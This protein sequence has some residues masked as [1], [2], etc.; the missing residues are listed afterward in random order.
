[1]ESCKICEW[2]KNKTR[3][4]YETSNNIIIQPDI[5]YNPYC[6]LVCPKKHYDNIHNMP[7]SEKKVLINETYHFGKKLE[8]KFGIKSVR[9]I[10]NNNFWKVSKSK[11]SLGHVHFNILAV[12]KKPYS[13]DPESRKIF[14][15]EELKVPREEIRGLFHQVRKR[16]IIIIEGI[17]GSGK[18]TIIEHLKSKITDAFEIKIHGFYFKNSKRCRNVDNLLR[19]TKNKII[20]VCDLVLCLEYDDVIISRFHISCN[21]LSKYYYNRVTDYK[22]LESHLRTFNTILILLDVS[23]KKVLLDRLKDRLN[24]GVDEVDVSPHINIDDLW[25]MRKDYLYYFKKSKI[26]NKLIFDTSKHSKSYV[27][28]KIMRFIEC[29]R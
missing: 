25:K 8:G 22:S 12:K 4:V 14:T 19:Y 10:Q 6:L 9:Y 26:K 7:D 28:S 5:T 29:Q 20:D 16:S 11:L 27:A 21:V 18:D 1:M 24:R 3:I 23:S 15:E 17:N 13:L 2:I